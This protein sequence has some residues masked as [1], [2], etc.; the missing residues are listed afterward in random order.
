MRALVLFGGTESSAAL[1][2]EIPIPILDPLLFAEADGRRYVLTSILEH[3]VWGPRAQSNLAAVYQFAGRLT[4]ALHLLELAEDHD[5]QAL[6]Y[7]DQAFNA[8]NAGDK[9]EDAKDKTVSASKKVGSAVG[10]KAGDVGDK[11]VD[12]SKNVGEKTVEGAKKV[13]AKTAEPL[14]R[15]GIEKR[16]RGQRNGR[17]HDANGSHPRRGHAGSPSSGARMRTA[18]SGGQP[19]SASSISACRSKRWSRATRPAS[20]DEKPVATSWARRHATNSSSSRTAS[21]PS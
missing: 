20:G 12:T 1:R 21:R 11:A 5:S 6:Y 2:H 7:V 3:P 17:F 13:G 18:S 10:D 15:V 16:R 14:L 4:E 9:A 8:R 19:P